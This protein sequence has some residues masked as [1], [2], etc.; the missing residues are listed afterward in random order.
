MI[1][2]ASKNVTDLTTDEF[3]DHEPAVSP[4][5]TLIAFVSDRAGGGFD[6]FLM[7]LASPNK[8]IIPISTGKSNVRHPA[9]SPGGR[10]IVFSGGEEGA[11]D[12]FIIDLNTMKVT[13]FTSGSTADLSPS[14]Q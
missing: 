9:W 4:D 8:D 7:D 2:L 6:L 13:T 10:Y 5:G 11:E 3:E 1:D 14:W 12:L